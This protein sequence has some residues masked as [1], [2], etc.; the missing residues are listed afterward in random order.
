MPSRPATSGATYIQHTITLHSGAEDLLKPLKKGGLRF[1]NIYENLPD[2]PLDEDGS[3]ETG[4][5]SAA[6][7]PKRS[8]PVPGFVKDW[9][10]VLHYLALVQSRDFLNPGG[11]VIST[12]GARCRCRNWPAWPKRRRT[13]QVFYLFLEG[14]DRSC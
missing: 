4:R 10:L 6:Y 12:I 8:E 14:A 2:L 1:D 13:S 11:V 9:M 5:T 3:L 7:I